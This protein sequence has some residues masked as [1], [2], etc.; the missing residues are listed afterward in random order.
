MARRTLLRTQPTSLLL[1][2]LL[3][4]A[5]AAIVWYFALRPQG[6][7]QA[8]LIDELEQ[9]LGRVHTVQ[10]RLTISLQN[11][12]LEQELWVQRPQRLRTETSAGP[13]A[14]KGTIVVLNQD[15]G[16]VYSPALNMAT[17][18]DRSAYSAEAAG[19]PGAGSLL[20]RMPDS[21]LA[22]LAGGS[23]IQ[24]GAAE[25][26][27]GRRATLLELTIPPGDASFPPGVLRVWLD[28]EFSY[29]LAWQDNTDR[30][31]RFSSI[32]FNQEIDPVTFTF[33]PPPGAGVHRIES[34]P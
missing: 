33:F 10:G 16:W 30:E 9:E 27:A 23:P 31:L 19:E 28:D 14:F 3:V 4:L 22:A 15:E 5:L 24:R 2:A 32:A 1:A 25:T 13:S 34:R 12:A 7:P 6:T 11:V 21:I 18:I 17:V 29:P 8:Q 20:E 26:I